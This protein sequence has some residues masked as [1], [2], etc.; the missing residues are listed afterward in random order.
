MPALISTGFIAKVEWLGV[1]PD[2]NAALESQMRDRLSLRF[3]GPEGEDHGGLTRPSC[4]RVAELYTRGT[5]I[6]NARQLSVLS[7]EELAETAAAMGLE[8]LDPALVGATLVVSGLSD[9]SH[10][11]PS[12]RLLAPGGASIVIDMNNRPCQL[13]ARPIENRFPGFGARYRRAAAGRRGVT[14]WVEA[15]G[16]LQLGDTL[17]LFIPDQRPWSPT[18]TPDA[19]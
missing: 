6:R 1:V 15:E 14:A 13:P 8:T 2:R 11:P 17:R 4:S 18:E 10:L 12:S 16:V 19:K 5:E 7:T 9:F 3:S